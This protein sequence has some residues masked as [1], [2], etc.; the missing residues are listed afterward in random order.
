MITNICDADVSA[1]LA[2]GQ[3]VP[4]IAAIIVAW[5]S[6]DHLERCSHALAAQTL[7]FWR[8]VVVD[9]ASPNF[10]VWPG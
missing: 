9:N 10:H 1:A 8:I 7:P 3:T 2:S 5:N 4:R 6:Y